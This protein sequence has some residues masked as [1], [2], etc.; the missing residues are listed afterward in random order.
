[1]PSG[2]ACADAPS[3]I[4]PVAVRKHKE[5]KKDKGAH[6]GSDGRRQ[7]ADRTTCSDE[8]RVA[9]HE[10]EVVGPTEFTT[11]TETDRSSKR[12]T[13]SV[14]SMPCHLT[15]GVG[16]DDFADEERVRNDQQKQKKKSKETFRHQPDQ[17][18][19]FGTI[20]G[21]GTPEVDHEVEVLDVPRQQG[22][23][24]NVSPKKRK[25]Q[26]RKLRPRNHRLPKSFPVEENH[27]KDT[28]GARKQKRQLQTGDGSD[29]NLG[30]TQENESEVEPGTSC[31]G[32]SHRQMY[33]KHTERTDAKG[34]ESQDLQLSL[35]HI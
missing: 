2:T 32:E 33:E 21:S 34:T 17:D 6:D 9:N 7:T 16:T 31:V 10:A 30:K 5:R 35:I 13:G 27:D 1:M 25:K 15:D 28:K 26:E 8:K 19:F 4:L 12:L 29:T 24:R 23:Q 18:P 22:E 20:P 14:D 11:K 3:L